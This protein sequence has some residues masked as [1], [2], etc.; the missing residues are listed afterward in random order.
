MGRLAPGLPQVPCKTTLNFEVPEN[1]LASLRKHMAV[2][3]FRCGSDAK[4][5]LLFIS[6]ILLN[7]FAE[8]SAKVKIICSL[9]AGLQPRD[10]AE[11]LADERNEKAK[12]RPYSSLTC[13]FYCLFFADVNLCWLS[14]QARV[15]SWPNERADVLPPRN[16]VKE[17][18]GKRRCFE[19]HHSYHHRWCR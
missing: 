3:I 11:S 17:F 2:S 15:P 16:L 10:F 6:Q 19:W 9:K 4:N 12:N 5:R 1:V 13:F 7:D 18:N 8:R 14:G